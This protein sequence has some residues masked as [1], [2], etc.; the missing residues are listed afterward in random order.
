MSLRL[1]SP[2]CTVLLAMATC[3]DVGADVPATPAGAPAASEAAPSAPGASPGRMQRRSPGK[4][5]API[6]LFADRSSGFEPGEAGVLE[7]KIVSGALLQGLQV[8]FR[9]GE[10]LELR[11]GGWF[12]HAAMVQVG[13]TLPHRIEVYAPV[14]GRY[15]ISAFVFADLGARR[16]ARVI[17]LPVIVG[18]PSEL[19]KIQARP[20]S[21][22][23]DSTGERIK[24]LRALQRRR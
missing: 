11:S 6:R 2:I 4:P 15:R 19:A 18:E 17:S 16:A 12:T 1:A 23:V 7:V 20:S 5:G 24:S 9:A 22:K 14:A 13:G 21:A 10:G 8:E 3:P